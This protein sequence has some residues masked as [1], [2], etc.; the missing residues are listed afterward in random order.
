MRFLPRH[1]G[2]LLSM[3]TTACA[4]TPAGLAPEGARDAADA[5][6]SGLA[7]PDAGPSEGG[8][9]DAGLD[10]GGTADAGTP[11]GDSYDAGPSD[12]GGGDAGTMCGAGLASSFPTF[13]RACS[14]DAD[15]TIGMHQTDCCG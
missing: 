9:G 3:L 6:D 7:G 10:A 15:C 4:C 2:A 11:D 1:L 5:Q 13:N 8:S 12:G 14:A